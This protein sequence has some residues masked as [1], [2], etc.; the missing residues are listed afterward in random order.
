MKRPILLILVALI[1]GI[2]I[3][4]F[5]LIDLIFLLL[6]I[7]LIYI[8]YTKYRQNTII[9]IL[10]LIIGYIITDFNVQYINKDKSYLMGEIVKVK[11][12]DDYR[13]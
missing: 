12:T 1:A 2:L 5:I 3:H 13:L 6:S 10:C 7:S 4:E 9:F 8:F 11:E